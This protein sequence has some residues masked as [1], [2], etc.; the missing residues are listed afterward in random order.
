MTEWSA[1]E[2]AGRVP[3]S[4]LGLDRTPAAMLEGR[5]CAC[6]EMVWANPERPSDGVRQHNATVDHM[7]W[8]ELVQERQGE[9]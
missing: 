2:Y 6:G 1:A 7:A 5:P 8:W 4:F 3:A 9:P